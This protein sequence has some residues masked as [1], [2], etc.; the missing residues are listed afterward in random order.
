MY[1]AEKHNQDAD[2]LSRRPHGLLFDDSESL[3]EE[4]RVKKFTS[5]HLS[6]SLK[7]VNLPDDVFKAA[8]CKHLIG[9]ADLPSFT[10]VESLALNAD[11]VPDVLQDTQDGHESVLTYSNEELIREQQSD[12]TISQVIQLLN[13]SEHSPHNVQTDSPSLRLM[14]KEWNRLEFKNGLL[15]RARHCDG[16]VVHQLVLPESL[17]PNVLKYLHNDMGHMGVERTLDLVR[18][19]FYWPKMFPDIE[20]K[21]KTCGRCVRRKTQPEKAAPLVNIHTTRPMELVCIDF[22]SL[23]PKYQRHSSDY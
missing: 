5:H 14:L 1:R 9:P 7:Q 4:E 15:Y 20:N 10:T 18:S 17:R 13:T 2:G 22:L 11:A 12:S 3:E 6:T 23:E 8:C 19:R 21:I 16:Q